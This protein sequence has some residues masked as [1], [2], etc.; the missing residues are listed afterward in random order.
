MTSGTSKTS[1]LGTASGVSKPTST[2]V[3]CSAADLKVID[4]AASLRSGGNRS[5]YV[6]KHALAA[7]EA[8]LRAANINPDDIRKAA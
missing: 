8:D 4:I 2:T 7:A 6:V 1:K 3:S 5:A